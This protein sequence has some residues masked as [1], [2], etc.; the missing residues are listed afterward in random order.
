MEIPLFIAVKSFFGL[1]VLTPFEQTLLKRLLEALAPHDCEILSYQISQ[2]TTVRRLT[3]HIDE[4]KAHGFTNFYTLRFG[5]D[6]S[7]KRQSK[8]FITNEPETLLA[9]VQVTFYRGEIEVQFWLVNGLL[10]NIEYRPKQKV[11]YPS[12]EFRIEPFTLWPNE[13]IR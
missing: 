1:Y 10:F 11:Y 6:V 8:R 7:E 9:T 13:K 12:G 5:K 2:F 4:P 3:R